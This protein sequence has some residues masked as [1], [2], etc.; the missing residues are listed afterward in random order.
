M[1]KLVS[2]VCEDCGAVFEAG[3]AARFCPACRKRRQQA[4]AKAERRC[5][6]CGRTFI[7]TPR[8]LY[9]PECRVVK[10]RENYQRHMA[11]KKKGRTI[12]RGETRGTCEVCGRTFVL[13][14]GGQ[15]YCP[16]CAKA[17][18]MEAD[19]RQSKAW[20][21]REKQKALQARAEAQEKDEGTQKAL[22]PEA[23]QQGGD[24]RS[25]G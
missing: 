20:A 19:R 1:A 4:Y 15:R 8:A 11:R 6:V 24:E 13:M 9:C 16:D 5:V 17:A 22:S 3:R 23:G 10:H 18:Y 21:E 25:G 2:H 7:G 12:V 14:A